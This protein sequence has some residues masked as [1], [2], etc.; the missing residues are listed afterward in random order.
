MNERIIKDTKITLEV[1]EKEEIVVFEKRYCTVCCIEQPLRVKHCRE[2]G[3]C[4]ALHD[5]HC[6]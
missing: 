2:C 3:K 4:I 5:H 6:P 1:D